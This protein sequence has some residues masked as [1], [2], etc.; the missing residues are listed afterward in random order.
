[1]FRI[2]SLPLCA[3]ALV[4]STLVILPAFAAEAKPAAATSGTRVFELRKY[5]AAPGKL[6]ALLA[7]FRDHTNAIFEK[8]G[9]TIIAFW[10]PTDGE[11]SK[12]T[13]IYILAFPSREAATKSW[14]DFQADP[15]WKAARA[16]SEKDGPL[17]VKGG[18]QSTFMSPTDFSA[19]K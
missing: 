11:A 15:V 18:V 16:E 19:I 1:M 13:L 2:A 9:M 3:F 7:R 10:V 12:N 14:A 5:T 17:L 4:A 8:H 6:D